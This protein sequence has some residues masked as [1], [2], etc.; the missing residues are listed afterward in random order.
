LGRIFIWKNCWN[1]YLNATLVQKL[2]G[3][4]MANLMTIP[5]PIFILPSKFAGGAHNIFLHVLIETGFIGFVIFMS[6]YI[7][8]LIKL[9][10]QSTYDKTVMAY[11]F[12][13]LS[14]LLSGFTQE[15]FWFQ[16]VFGCLWLYHTCLLALI[17][18]NKN[19]KTGLDTAGEKARFFAKL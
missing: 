17:L 13:T 8:V 18:D 11:F 12:I 4:G 15:I 9:Y 10:R 2:F 16:P 14:L 7:S 1:Y 3:V 5:F 6:F 19:G